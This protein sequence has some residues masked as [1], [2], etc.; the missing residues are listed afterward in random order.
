MTT[1]NHILV[2]QRDSSKEVM[3]AIF[4][5]SRT[6]RMQFGYGDTSFWI[7]P[8]SKKNNQEA[9]ERLKAVSEFQKVSLITLNQPINENDV[10]KVRQMLGEFKF[11]TE[12]I[13]DLEWVLYLN[14]LVEG[15]AEY[16][17]DIQNDSL[18]HQPPK[19]RVKLLKD[20]PDFSAEWLTVKSF[21]IENDDDREYT[22]D[23]F[24]IIHETFEETINQPDE[25]IPDNFFPDNKMDSNDSEKIK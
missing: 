25:T 6:A 24:E 9:I 23:D 5:T 22:I 3:V 13:N 11:N 19:L 16:Y 14:S 10:L 20:H 4:N 1:Y 7:M 21:P 17:M 12:A 15:K 2:T 8:N 18:F